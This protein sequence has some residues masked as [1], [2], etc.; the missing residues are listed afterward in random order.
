MM[1]TESTEKTL[2]LGLDGAAWRLLHPLMEAGELPNLQALTERGASGYLHSAI[3]PLSAPAWTNFQTGANAGKHSVFDFR[4]FDRA[5]REVWLVSSRDIQLPSL[6]QIATVHG[7]R[8][9]AINVP[10]TYPPQPVNGII[11]GGMLTPNEDRTLIYPSERFEEIF[12]RH[13][14]YQVSPPTIAQRGT[15]GR[16]AFVDANIKVERQRYE[17]ALNL[18]TREPW[19][20]FVLQNQCLDYI[21]HAYYHLL[22]RTAAEFDPAGYAEVVRFYQ[23]MDENLGRLAEAAPPGTDIVVLSDHGFKLQHR[24]IHLAPWLRYEGYLV[25]RIRPRQ[26][27]LQL[28]R[29]I[30]VL[31]LRRHLAHLVLRDKETRFGAAAT[32]ALSRVEWTRSQAYVAIGSVF[33]CIYVNHDLV[34]DVEGVSEELTHRLLQMTDPKDGRRVVARVLRGRDIYHGPFAHNGADLI[35]EPAED[36]TF[37]APS[38]VAHKEP[39]TDID[40]DLEIPGGHHPD[41]IL[42]WTGR[43]IRRRKDI[44]ADLMDVAP[45]V[46]ARMGLPVPDHMDGQVLQTPF[47]TAPATRLEPWQPEDSEGSQGDYSA[48]DEEILERRLGDLGYL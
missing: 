36:Y 43:G 28:A 12:G 29:Q 18:M 14:D 40:F 26:R 32:T 44:S 9:I 8:V 35:A 7:C 4:V 15:M 20:V 38:L 21:Q 3:P 30:D 41:G 17:L 13:P 19:D 10:V 5:A 48:S 45:T 1:M 27:L 33:G 37:G 47:E 2:I 46:L 39:F 42:L 31:K 16:R 23:A 6:W 34:S 11:I 24:L 22:D 25:E